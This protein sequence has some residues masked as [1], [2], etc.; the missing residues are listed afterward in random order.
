MISLLVFSELLE[1]LHAPPFESTQWERFLLLLSR[2]TQSTLAVF[3]CADYF[4][5]LSIRAW[6]TSR[7]AGCGDVQQALSR[8]RSL[9]RWP[10]PER[11]DGVFQGSEVFADRSFVESVLYLELM[12][13]LG[14][15]HVTLIPLA[16]SVRRF[17]AIG[18]WRGHE[19]GP[20]GE[21]CNHLLNLLFPHIQ[22]ALQTRQVLGVTWQ[23][24]AGAETMADASF[25]ATLVVTREG[26]VVHSNAAANALVAEGDCVS[27]I[28]RALKPTD[29]GLREA[30]RTL[31]L[32]AA[33]HVFAPSAPTP[34]HALSPPRP[35]GR[36]PMQLLVMQ[37]PESRVSKSGTELRV[38]I[39]DPERKAWFSDDVMHALYSLTPA[40]NDVAHSRT[41]PS[42]EAHDLPGSERIHPGNLKCIWSLVFPLGSGE[43]ERR[44][45]RRGSRSL[46]TLGPIGGLIDGARY[47]A[48]ALAVA[49]DRKNARQPGNAQ[50]RPRPSREPLTWPTKFALLGPEARAF[51][52]DLLTHCFL[53]GSGCEVELLD[54]LPHL[55]LD[56][57]GHVTL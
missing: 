46:H 29:E 19:H 42:G 9:S 41:Q 38:S 32:K 36:Q 7:E 24:L 45:Q 47:V 20:M 37:L 13:P 1:A 30:F 50:D 8:K 28:D 39:S 10:H 49:Q 21:D 25:T 17:E 43:R 26:S 55:D 11:K 15:R 14:H 51:F 33:S 2:H 22:E 27:L 31:Y 18:I 48:C 56:D 16:L 6:R 44:L 35:V 52:Q 40:E 57:P 12:R 54:I 5:G 23:R 3:L 53:I 34:T 4:L